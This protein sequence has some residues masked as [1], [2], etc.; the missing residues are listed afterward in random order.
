[1]KVLDVSYLHVVNRDDELTGI[2]SFRDIR[3]ALQEETLS[4]LVIAR[5]V[6]TKDIVTIRPSDSILLAL[7]EMGSRGISQLPVVSEDTGRKVIGTVS[8]RDVMATYD[9]AI[10][11]REVEGV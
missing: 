11:K 3:S 10:L 9:R 4:S 5:D 6:A 7:Q 2:I 1:L 8:Q